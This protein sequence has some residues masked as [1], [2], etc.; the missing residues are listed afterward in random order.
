MRIIFNDFKNWEFDQISTLN[1]EYLDT[2]IPYGDS[3]YFHTLVEAM[4]EAG[5]IRNIR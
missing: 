5:G 2:S 4:V 1:F 3:D